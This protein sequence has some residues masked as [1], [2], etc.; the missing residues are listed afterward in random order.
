MLKTNTLHVV[1]LE[2]VKVVQIEL[3]KCYDDTS[4]FFLYAK[5]S[6]SLIDTMSFSMLF[7]QFSTSPISYGAK[8]NAN[9]SSNT[10]WADKIHLPSVH[11]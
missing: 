8:M 6:V 2:Y 3:E 11:C 4:L 7:A 1:D 9:E 10:S 5:L